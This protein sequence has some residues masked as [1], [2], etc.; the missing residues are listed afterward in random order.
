MLTL[1]FYKDLGR[2]HLWLSPGTTMPVRYL[3]T[4]D[5]WIN[6]Y[7]GLPGATARRGL[8]ANPSIQDWVRGFLNGYVVGD[9]LPRLIRGAGGGYAMDPP[10]K[11]L[12]FPHSAI[13]EMR[14]EHTRTFG[15]FASDRSF[16][17]DRIVLTDTLKT[18]RSANDT[19]YTAIAKSM[20]DG[21]MRRL[22]PTELDQTSDVNKVI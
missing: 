16:V 18:G 4:T 6:E 20:L 22:N 13:V 7:H 19:A 2:L 3:F 9:P 12:R 15:F 1:S 10:F 21:W 11:R 14:T 5:R 8:Q 17:A